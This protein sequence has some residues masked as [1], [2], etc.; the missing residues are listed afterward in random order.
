MPLA[1]HRKM[2]YPYFRGKQYELI[3]IRETAHIFKEQGFIPIIE[4]VKEQLNSLNKTLKTINENKAKAIIVINPQL[5]DHK[6]NGEEICSLLNNE[7]KTIKNILKGILLTE[8]LSVDDAFSLL[9]NNRKK[10]EIALIHAGFSHAKELSKKIRGQSNIGTSIFLENFCGKLYRR[11]FKNHSRILIRDGFQ[12]RRNRDHPPIEFFSDLHITFEEEQM[13]GFGDFLIVGDEYSETG[14]PAYTVAIHLTYID[15]E[16]DDEMHIYHFK[17][18]RQ[19][20]PKDPAGKFAE[21]LKKLI[22]ELRKPSTNI[23]DTSAIQEFKSLHQ[24]G[25]FPGLGYIKKLSMKHHIETLARYFEDSGAI[26][27]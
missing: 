17:S 16:K 24:R 10:G 26:D 27:T 25:H 6:S 3:T 8:E 21:A 12:Q 14:G 15:H 19:D 2:Y 23:E 18:D 9:Q 1:G 11:H 5:G 4:P 20:T 13:N 7:P 22:R